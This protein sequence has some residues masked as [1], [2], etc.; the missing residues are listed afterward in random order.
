VRTGAYP[1]EQG[2]KVKEAAE[3]VRYEVRRARRPQ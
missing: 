2:L 3:L 1:P